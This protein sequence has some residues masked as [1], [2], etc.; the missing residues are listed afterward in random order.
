MDHLLH[1]FF[2]IGDSRCRKLDDFSNGYCP[3]VLFGDESLGV[4]VQC[5]NVDGDVEYVFVHGYF[6]ISVSNSFMALAFVFSAMSMYGRMA[7]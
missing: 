6:C 2:S 5:A 7:L 4:F 3:A 1:D